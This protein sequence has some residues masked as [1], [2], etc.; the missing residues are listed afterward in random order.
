MTS[1]RQFEPQD[2]FRLNLTNLDP[3]T[4]NYNIDFYLHYITKWPFL[5]T[6][7]E[8]QESNVVGYSRLKIKYSRIPT[9]PS[10]PLSLVFTEKKIFPTNLC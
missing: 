7:A 2:I 9:V 8:D 4:E 5:F 6:V 3:L 10:P 1:L